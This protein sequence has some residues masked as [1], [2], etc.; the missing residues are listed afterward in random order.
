MKNLRTLELYAVR[1]DANPDLA[2]IIMNMI[3]NTREDLG[4]KASKTKY[5]SYLKTNIK[6][7][8][9]DD[10]RKDWRKI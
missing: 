9:T 4:P 5:L 1:E 2:M 6:E 3:Q 10:M 8:L 7:R